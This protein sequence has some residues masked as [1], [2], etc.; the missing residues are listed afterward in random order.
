MPI[1]NAVHLH[2]GKTRPQS[3]PTSIRKYSMEIEKALGDM[4][5]HLNFLKHNIQSVVD[6]QPD[7]LILEED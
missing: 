1:S 2:G 4:G 7:G 3:H 6:I 5:L